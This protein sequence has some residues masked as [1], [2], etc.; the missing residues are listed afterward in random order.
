MTNEE[1]K[2]FAITLAKCED[3]KQVINLLKQYGFWDDDSCWRHFGDIENNYSTIGNQQASSDFALVEKI[4]NS[5]DAVI[6]G[7]LLSK[8]IDPSSDLAP[9]TITEYLK[10]YKE[11]PEGK[12]SLLDSKSRSELAKDILLVSTKNP[13]TNN[14]NYCIIDGGEGQTPKSM[15]NTILSISAS[16]KMRVGAVQGKFNMGGT[17]V[18]AFSGEHKFEIIISKKR[19]DIPIELRLDDTFDKWSVTIVRKESPKGNMKSSCFRYL[20]PKGDILMFEA[21]SLKLKPRYNTKEAVPYEEEMQWGT[22]IKIFDYSIRGANKVS[23]IHLHDRLSLLIPEIALPIKIIET[24]KTEAKRNKTL[25]GLTARLDE[26]KKEAL[27]TDPIGIL[28]KIDGETVKANIYIF[29]SGRGESYKKNEGILYTMNGQCQ[30]FESSKF[31]KSLNLSY[32]AD[33]LLVV[34]DCSQ[35]SSKT[36]ED[37][38]LNSRDRLKKGRV[39]EE[40]IKFLTDSIKEMKE[41]KSLNNKR[42]SEQLEDKIGESKIICNVVENLISKSKIL[43]R[44]LVEGKDIHGPVNGKKYD[45]AQNTLVETNKFPTYF[46]LRKNNRTSAEIGRKIRIS[47]DTDAEND[48][49][50]RANMPGLYTL[51]VNGNTLTDCSIHILNGIATLNINIHEDLFNIGEIYDFNLNITDDSRYEPINVRFELIVNKKSDDHGTPPKTPREG[52]LKKEKA[53]PFI[54]E[55]RKD[56]WDKFGFDNTSAVRIIKKDDTYDFICNLDNKYLL[57][58][59]LNSKSDAK[60][61]ESMFTTALIVSSMSIISHYSSLN[62]TKNESNENEVDIEKIVDETTKALAPTVIP[63]IKELGNLSEFQKS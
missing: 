62:K 2:R 37:L 30:G 16:N 36:V 46:K 32:I 34:V 14:P 54:K 11:I 39:R 50:T 3:E 12:L 33:S 38:F 47:L 13:S 63:T 26:N 22:F 44:L 4:I 55:I 17:G 25:Y 27:E 29:K 51:K 6:M 43:N 8:N 7:D 45:R 57:S 10:K 40:L 61:L 1:I 5:I 18:L 52:S 19:Q 35:L 28:G 60:I 41:L 59:I 31:F 58:E 21:D 20:A 23:T 24:R 56:E 53:M 48:Y 42:R 9:K 15:P 49:F